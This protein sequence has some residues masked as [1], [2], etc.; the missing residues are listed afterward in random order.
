MRYQRVVWAFDFETAQN[1][2]GTESEVVAV[3]WA[4]TKYPDKV[5][6]MGKEKP[7]QDLLKEF[8]ENLV[9]QVSKSRYIGRDNKY[10]ML[11]AHNGSRFDNKFIR[12]WLIKS[13]YKMGGL[14]LKEDDTIEENTFYMLAS[15]QQG[16][17]RLIFNIKGYIIDIKDFYKFV[18]QP[19]SAIGKMV[20]V[21][22]LEGFVD[23]YGK[24]L[25]DLPPERKQAYLE[26]CKT[27]TQILAKAIAMFSAENNL[28]VSNKV[29][30]LPGMSYRD[31]LSH[32]ASYHNKDFAKRKEL[33][34]SYKDQLPNKRHYGGGYTFIN[35][36]Y[37]GEKVDNVYYY[38]INSSY[39]AVMKTP[40][41]TKVITKEEYEGLNP[42]YKTTILKI[43][44]RNIQIKPN[45]IANLRLFKPTA[46][47]IDDGGIIIF[48]SASFATQRTN[49]TSIYYIWENEWPWIANNYDLEYEILE[50]IYIKKELILKDYIVDLEKE[51]IEATK[52]MEQCKQNNDNDGAIN[53]SVKRTIA[54]LKQNSVY[55]RF[56]QR[57]VFF[58][59]LV[60]EKKIK[61]SGV[62]END[63]G[64]FL[65][66]NKKGIEVNNQ[67]IYN[68]VDFKSLTSDPDKQHF[69]INNHL[70]SGYITSQARI[71]LYKQIEYVGYDNFIYCDT[72]SIFTKVPLR[73]E[74]IHPEEY[75]KWKLEGIFYFK[76]WGPKVYLKSTNPEYPLR[77]G[78]IVCRGIS[79]PTEGLKRMGVD[80]EHFKWNDFQRTTAYATTQFRENK[81][82]TVVTKDTTKTPY[83]YQK[84]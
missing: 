28:I 10:I 6:I 75:G 59:H 4:S 72:D 2:A 16:I 21:N 73:A 71:A 30:T 66:A 45:S 74:D 53:A 48:S 64:T 38:D 44:I 32:K 79:N 52:L 82:G 68:V 19:L 34:M 78:T 77:D 69:R 65:V 43:A 63:F 18:N 55:G 47:K 12:E 33:V 35:P 54:K 61:N 41:A 1:E 24:Y 49:K 25:W 42:L 26:Y 39:P 80:I 23:C 37:V 70:I 56:A 84:H 76:G 67:T 5:W 36:K 81:Q 46:T 13:G 3:S 14:L 83:R 57:E 9:N 31:F 27:D 7:E 40:V 17:L 20:G 62:L 22:K 29:N 8:F 15:D 51:K 11:F 60:S 50:E 58:N